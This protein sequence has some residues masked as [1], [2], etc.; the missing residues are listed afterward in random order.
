MGP[1]ILVIPL[2]VLGYGALLWLLY[3][4]CFSS[5]RPYALST[6]VFSCV[7]GV[8]FTLDKPHNLDLYFG[9][10]VLLGAV[11][12]GLHAVVIVVIKKLL[13]H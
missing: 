7:T 1:E 3:L 5:I 4:A 2:E 10:G 8:W 9:L 6:L 13:R 12:F 11:L